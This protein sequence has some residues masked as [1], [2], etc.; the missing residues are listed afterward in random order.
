MIVLTV[1]FFQEGVYHTPGYAYQNVQGLG[2][3][4]RGAYRK[5]KY[6]RYKGKL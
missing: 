1:S 5:K 2:K 3:G 6:I 4:K